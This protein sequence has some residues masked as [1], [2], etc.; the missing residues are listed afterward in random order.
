MTTQCFTTARFWVPIAMALAT[1][2][3]LLFDQRALAL[4]LGLLIPPVAVLGLGRCR[5]VPR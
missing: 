1:A 3:L 4:G 5:Q 2:T